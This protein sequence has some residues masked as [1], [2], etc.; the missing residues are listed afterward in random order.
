MSRWE[1][2][3]RFP[4]SSFSVFSAQLLHARG[5]DTRP[6]SRSQQ[7]VSVPG[8]LSGDTE[9]RGLNGSAFLPSGSGVDTWFWRNEG[10]IAFQGVCGLPRGR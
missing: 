3:A 8:L 7:P 9:G 2:G 4:L 6:P 1:A 5:S 10:L